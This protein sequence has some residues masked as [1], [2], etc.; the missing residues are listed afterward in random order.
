MKLTQKTFRAHT[1]NQWKSGLVNH[2]IDILSVNLGRERQGVVT[3]V[4]HDK[5]GTILTF[6]TGKCYVLKL[7]ILGFGIRAWWHMH[8]KEAQQGTEED[9]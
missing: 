9:I 3:G 2:Y 7:Y 5:D 4:K 6:H 1:D 8:N